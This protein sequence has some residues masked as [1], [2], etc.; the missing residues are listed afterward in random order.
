MICHKTTPLSTF[1]AIEWRVNKVDNSISSRLRMP[2]VLR[3]SYK[4]G[5]IP[6][7]WRSVIGIAVNRTS[8]K[9]V[10]MKSVIL[11][12][13]VTACMAAQLP[14]RSYLP[15]T[16]GSHNTAFGSSSQYTSFGTQGSHSSGSSFGPMGSG[17]GSAIRPQQEADKN[18]QILKSD[19]D[20]TAEGFHYSYETSNGIRAE[21]SGDSSQSRG[22]FSY[23]GDDGNTYTVT[24]TAGEA[25]FL[26]QGAHLPI[27]PP[28]PEV[29]LLALEQNA[30]DEA[31]GI[32]DDGTYNPAKHGGGQYSAGQGGSH[33]SSQ[34]SS[35][36]SSSSFS[37]SSS[38]SSFGSASHQGTFNQHTGYR[39]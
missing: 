3:F 13:A 19:Q 17:G 30:K 39:Y 4:I 23:K 34:S 7:N 37:S 18:A 38:Q 1:S 2:R 20:V 16:S 15:P 31:A 26:P 35:S 29:I 27:A 14:T 36:S 11:A 10:N 21:E 32:F 33:S 8:I 5:H 24:F 22:G 12:L 6:L 9:K 28:T 25:G